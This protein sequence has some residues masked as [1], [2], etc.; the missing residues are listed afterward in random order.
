MSLQIV[1][2][3]TCAIQRIELDDNIIIHITP[4]QVHVIQRFDIICLYERTLFDS[5]RGMII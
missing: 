2:F 3:L 4:H 1:E 5:Q